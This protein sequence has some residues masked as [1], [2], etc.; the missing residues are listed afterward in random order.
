MLLMWL[1]EQITE[2]GIGNGISLIITIGILARLP[3]AVQGAWDMFFP[4]AA[5]A[6]TNP[7]QLGS[8]R[9]VGPVALRGYRWHHRRD[10]G[11]TQNSRPI[12]ST[13]CWS[14]N[15]FRWQLVHAAARQL[16]WRYASH[17]RPGIADVPLHDIALGRHKIQHAVPLADVGFSWIAV[18]SSI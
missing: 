2:R 5:S 9:R 4:P 18:R 8:R 7:F 1:G 14:Q 11:A 6:D 16:R 13:R 10:P 17:L 12:R 15:L 3:A